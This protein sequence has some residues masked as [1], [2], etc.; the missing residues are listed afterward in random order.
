MPFFNEILAN[1]IYIEKDENYKE[2]LFAYSRYA[3]TKLQEKGYTK[4]IKKGFYFSTF[5]LKINKR[6]N[7][8]FVIPIIA[9]IYSLDEIDLESKKDEF[10][11]GIEITQFMDEWN[12]D[13]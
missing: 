11:K 1:L 13:Y 4:Y 8:L 5:K 10:L 6:N 7:K 2:N 3:V 9:S 12:K